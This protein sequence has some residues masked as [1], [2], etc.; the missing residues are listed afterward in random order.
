[1]SDRPLSNLK[2]NRQAVK[3]LRRRRNRLARRLLD[4]AY[5]EYLREL[6]PRDDSH[7]SSLSSSLS[8]PFLPPPP[9]QLS[10]PSSINQISSPLQS[11][12]LL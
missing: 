6:G 7:L 10:S 12:T 9:P 4:E 11:P 3:R 8:V 1:M 5:T 2:V